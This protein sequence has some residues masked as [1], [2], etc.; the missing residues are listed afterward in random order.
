MGLPIMR[1][2]RTRVFVG[3]NHKNFVTFWMNSWEILIVN[4]G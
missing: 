3:E 1:G 4:K 2:P